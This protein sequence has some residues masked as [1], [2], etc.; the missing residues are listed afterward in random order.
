MNR[1][2]VMLIN[3]MLLMYA[4]LSECGP[5]QS[6][7]VMVDF[8]DLDR[9]EEEAQQML[10][11][12][13]ADKWRN[14]FNY[15]ITIENSFSAV[16]MHDIIERRGLD[17]KQ[18]DEKSGLT[19][20]QLAQQIGN[21][22]AVHYLLSRGVADDNPVRSAELLKRIEGKITEV[23]HV[24]YRQDAAQ[25]AF[26]DLNVTQTTTAAPSIDPQ[27]SAQ[28]PVPAPAIVS[29]EILGYTGPKRL[30]ESPKDDDD[31]DN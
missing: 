5:N 6:V 1:R 12:T 24:V 9:A 20:L 21:A 29:P 31:D 11:T 18:K 7:P 8:D 28:Q 25:Q 4:L 3:V 16:G 26:I 30:K 19:P 17:F 27:Q 14:M 23:N 10:Q 15:Y 2:I 13:E 22:I